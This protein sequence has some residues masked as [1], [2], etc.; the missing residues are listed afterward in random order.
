[1]ILKDKVSLHGAVSIKAGRREDA[2]ANA[3]PFCIES[4]ITSEK[5]RSEV[6]EKI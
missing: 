3:L 2:E 4:E 5:R 6:S 1:M